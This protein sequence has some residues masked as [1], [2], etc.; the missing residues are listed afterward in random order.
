MTKYK[1]PQLLAYASRVKNARR[2]AARQGAA[3]TKSRA[4]DP[5]AMSFGKFWLINPRTNGVIFGGEHG[6]DLDAI[7]KKIEAGVWS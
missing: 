5:K 1:D 4:R 2:R 7:E 6:R 3:L